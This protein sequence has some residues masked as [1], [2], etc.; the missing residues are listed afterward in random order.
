MNTREVCSL[1]QL[2]DAKGDG[3]QGVFVLGSFCSGERVA[4]SSQQ[5]RALNL[6]HSLFA[7]KQLG[8]GSRV[9][10][11]GG[12]AAGLTAAAY[13]IAK[14]AVVTVLESHDLLWNLRGCRT[15]WLHPNLFRCWPHEDWKCTGTN[16]P[17]MNWY[18]GYASEVGELM[19]LKY[20]SFEAMQESRGSRRYLRYPGHQF[21]RGI[22]MARVTD[23]WRVSWVT[24]KDSW[25][26]GAD[27][28]RGGES[29]LV[30]RYAGAGAALGKTDAVFDL[31]DGGWGID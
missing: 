24:P 22:Q 6:V 20:L 26:G 9:C 29:L 30:G 18:A 1:Y 3:H 7:E 27:A 14:E 5:T 2:T 23:G 4:V 8:P 17:V 25:S 15:R 13:A 16:F 19:H 12:G 31:R 21:A 10:V 28:R 11:V